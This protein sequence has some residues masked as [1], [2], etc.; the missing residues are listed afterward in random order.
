MPTSPSRLTRRTLF[1]GAGAIGALAATVG[2][3]PTAQT[4]AQTE[5][6]LPPKPERGGGYVESERVKQYYRTTRV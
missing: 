3:R 2:V 4:V 1:A 6:P 5:Q